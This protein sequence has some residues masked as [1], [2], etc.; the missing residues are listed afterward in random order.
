MKDKV[1]FQSDHST[2][3]FDSEKGS[4]QLYIYDDK[5]NLQGTLSFDYETMNVQQKSQNTKPSKDV[6]SVRLSGIKATF[7][8]EG[9]DVFL[10][11]VYG[12]TLR[13]T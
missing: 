1:L 7:N 9:Y 10:Q 12:N 5:N 4:K 8:K 2:N 11:I 6:F 3:E 13:T